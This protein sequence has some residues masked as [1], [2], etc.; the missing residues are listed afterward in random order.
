MAFQVKTIKQS[1]LTAE[2]WLVQ[3]W[4]SDVCKT[5]DVRN[6]SECGGKHIRKTK[7][8]SKGYAVPLN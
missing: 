5:C 7:K 1:E 2:C 3:I 4:G 6:T 8:N